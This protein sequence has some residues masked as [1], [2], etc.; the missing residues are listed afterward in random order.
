MAGYAG[1]VAICGEQILARS[2]LPTERKSGT[3]GESFRL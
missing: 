3:S 2:L 1:I